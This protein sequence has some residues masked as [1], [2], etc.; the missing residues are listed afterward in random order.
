MVF[1]MRD[2]IVL[3]VMILAVIFMALISP[4]FIE[5]PYWV[6]FGR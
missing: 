5:V 2:L 4:Y 3:F 6:Y 1:A